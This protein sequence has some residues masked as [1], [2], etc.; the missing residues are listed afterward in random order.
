MRHEHKAATF[1]RVKRKEKSMKKVNR[2]RGPPKYKLEQLN[3]D[4]KRDPCLCGT[5]TP[6]LRIINDA[7]TK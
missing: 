7:Q 4:V 6:S 5:W 1:G 3:L 2:Q